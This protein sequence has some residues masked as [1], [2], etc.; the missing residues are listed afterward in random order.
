MELFVGHM[1]GD[2]LLQNDWMARNKAVSSFVCAV[3]VLM[4]GAAMNGCNLLS[5]NPSFDVAEMLLIVV[6]HYIIDRFRLARKYMGAIGQEAFATGPCAPWS[7]IVVDQ[8]LHAV[9]LG[10][11]SIWMNFVNAS[12]T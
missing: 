7:V 6:P 12:V 5:G 10:L 4:Y 8:A 3:H 11:F 2:Y 9:C 1:V